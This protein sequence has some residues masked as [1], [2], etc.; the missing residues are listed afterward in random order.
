MNFRASI[1]WLLAG[2]LAASTFWNVR[3]LNQL[4]RAEPAPPSVPA[5]ST[6]PLPTRIVSR[7][8]LSDEQ[9]ELIRCCGMT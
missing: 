8:S 3:L 1:L 7:L 6:S 4:E 9:C 5:A 2:G